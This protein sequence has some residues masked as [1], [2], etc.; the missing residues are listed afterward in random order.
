MRKDTGKHVISATFVN[1]WYRIR[2]PPPPISTPAF[3]GSCLL[4]PITNNTHAFPSSHNIP[5][6][7][8][9]RYYK[10]LH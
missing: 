9:Y 10:N 8:A 1:H 6:I 7:C 3:R 2:T 5:T 4:T